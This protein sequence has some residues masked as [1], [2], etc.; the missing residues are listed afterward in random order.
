M[1]KT[2][3][4][5]WLK[6][7]NKIEKTEVFNKDI[8]YQLERASKYSE[9]LDTFY[10][11]CDYKTMK[12]LVSIMPFKCRTYKRDRYD[13]DD[14]AYDFWRT[15]KNMFPTLTVGVC[16]VSIPH[17]GIRHALNWCITSDKG[18]FMIEPQS[19]KI[20]FPNYKIEVMII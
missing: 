4:L 10:T 1:I 9:R 8:D 3:K 13:C 5:F 16:H 20:F 6:V 2:I 12:T 18:F 14:F 15:L 19:G 11:T 17:K 7:R